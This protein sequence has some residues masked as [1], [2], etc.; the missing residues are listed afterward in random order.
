MGKRTSP[1]LPGTLRQLTD[2]GERLRLARRR[3]N[4]TAKQVADRA[5]MTTVTLRSIE[6]G[7]PG[8]TMGAYLAVLQVLG[9]DEELG[10]IALADS[11]G[12]ALQ[13][14]RLGPPRRRKAGASPV[15]QEPAPQR[16][17][18]PAG[19]DA[20]ADGSGAITSESLQALLKPPRRQRAPG[21]PAKAR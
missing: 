7:S 2:L 17:A 4:L 10:G 5:G 21:K 1:L 6:R 15:A 20:A 14:A 12:R 8:A 18:I 3:R 9:L 13:D 11:V 16:H 19:T